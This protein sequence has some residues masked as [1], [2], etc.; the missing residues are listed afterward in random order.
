MLSSQCGRASVK[1]RFKVPQGR[2]YLMTDTSART[3]LCG[4]DL[5]RPAPMRSGKRGPPMD[6]PIGPKHIA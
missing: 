6:V 3:R 4:S 2:L 5:P 1:A